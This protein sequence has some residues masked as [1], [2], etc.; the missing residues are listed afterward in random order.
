M[1]PAAVEP[2]GF[3]GRHGGSGGRGLGCIAGAGAVQVRGEGDL[4]VEGIVRPCGGPFRQGVPRPGRFTGHGAEGQ[5]GLGA[6]LGR[7]G[8]EQFG[9][10][11]LGGGAPGE[12]DFAGAQAVDDQPRV[13]VAESGQSRCLIQFAATVKGPQ[14][15]DAGQRIGA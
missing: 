8:G 10:G 12:C 13:G 3:L 7:R 4:T 1:A 11:R 14:G 6:H 2:G 15:V 5:Q 9:D